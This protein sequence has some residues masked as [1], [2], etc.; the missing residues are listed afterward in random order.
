LAASS[1]QDAKEAEE[2]AAAAKKAE[3]EKAAA[4]KAAASQDKVRRVGGAVGVWFTGVWQ[5]PAVKLTSACI[6][7]MP[8]THPRTTAHTKH[9]LPP[10]LAAEGGGVHRV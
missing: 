10:R 9:L 5:L 2:K 1:A 7:G 4:D 8:M 3:E 6:A